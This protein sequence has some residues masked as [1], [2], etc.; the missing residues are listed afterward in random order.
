MIIPLLKGLKL[1]LKY[2]FSKKITLR[3][4]E[5]K[6]PVA[7]RWRGRHVLTVYPTGKIRCVACMLCAT[8]CPAECIKIV[9]AAEPDNR[10]YPESY[11]LDLGRC[12]F[13]G[14]CVDVCPRQA[15]EMS[16]VYELSEYSRESLILDKETLMKPPAERYVS[17]KRKAG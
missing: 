15:I 8:V 2:F 13:C 17:E 14:H 11:E 5:E 7:P 3:Y 6:W 4:P 1:T 16:T 12:I 9:A 10:K